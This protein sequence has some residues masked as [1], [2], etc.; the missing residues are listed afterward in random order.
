MYAKVL[1]TPESA[2]KLKQLGEMGFD[3]HVSFAFT[4]SG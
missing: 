2:A 1:D 4:L 3:R